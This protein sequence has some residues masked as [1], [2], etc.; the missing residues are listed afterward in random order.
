M[1]CNKANSPVSDHHCE[2]SREKCEISSA[3]TVVNDEE[4]DEGLVEAEWSGADPEAVDKPQEEGGGKGSVAGTSRVGMRLVRP[5]RP[6]R[7]SRALGNDGRVMIVTA[8]GVVSTAVESG[9]CT[10]LEMD[11][12]NRG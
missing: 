9:C 3:L 6:C 10:L 2:E 1:R 12:M 8:G 5:T 11:E 7:A 4:D